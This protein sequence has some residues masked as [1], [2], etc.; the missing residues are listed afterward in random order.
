MD[1]GVHGYLG[2][3]VNTVQMVCIVTIAEAT[4]A[5]QCI[6]FKKEYIIVEN[7]PE[8]IH[9][10]NYWHEGTVLSLMVKIVR[11]VLIEV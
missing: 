11:S 1:T 7:S 10:A 5:A 6:L 2:V 4:P 3:S 9:W 8:E